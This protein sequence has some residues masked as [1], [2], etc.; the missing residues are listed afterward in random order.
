MSENLDLV[1]SIY[2]DWERGDFSR[3]DWADAEVEFV[4]TGGL[5]DGSWKGLTAIGGAWRD[6]LSAWNNMR[7]YAEEYREIDGERVF[8]L[9]HTH[10]RG[11]A[12]GVELEQTA[13]HL[14]QV[15]DGKVIKLV[16]YWDRDRALAELGL[17]PEGDAP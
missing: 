15:R 13:A 6:I 16:Q 8:V 12:S 4:S 2:G 3:A 7:V 14:F 10:G 5:E 1:R 9:M 17:A 11:E